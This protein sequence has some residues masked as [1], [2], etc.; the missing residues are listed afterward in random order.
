MEYVVEVDLEYPER[1]HN[2]LSGYPLT[3]ETMTIPKTWLSDYQ[4]D[5]GNKFGGNYAECIKSVPNLCEKYIIIQPLYHVK[6]LVKTL[7]P[8]TMIKLKSYCTGS[9][10]LV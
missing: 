9:Y 4:L 8:Y 7:Q 1:L 10:I 2:T 6:Y 5:F 3:P